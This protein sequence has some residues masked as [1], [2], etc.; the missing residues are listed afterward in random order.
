MTET[1]DYLERLLQVKGMPEG[2]AMELL[3][4]YA[5]ELAEKIRTALPIG[6]C[7]CES[8][9][10]YRRAADLIDPEVK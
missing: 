6:D 5:H 4:A 7:D 1:R 8:C 2:R 10:A 3:E 9:T